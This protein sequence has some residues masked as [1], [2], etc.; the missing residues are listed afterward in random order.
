MLNLKS[1]EGQ[2]FQGQNSEML[3]WLLFGRAAAQWQNTSYYMQKV[4]SLA[5]P[6]STDKSPCLENP[7]ASRED[8]IEIDGAMFKAAS[9]VWFCFRPQLLVFLNDFAQKCH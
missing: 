5:F 8:I 7:V 2:F 4:Q 6:G 9:C 1:K 3:A